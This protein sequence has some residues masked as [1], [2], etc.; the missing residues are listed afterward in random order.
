MLRHISRRR[1]RAGESAS[2][3][4]LAADLTAGHAAVPPLE[5]AGSFGL[6]FLGVALPLELLP[7]LLVQTASVATGLSMGFAEFAC[8][9]QARGGRRLACL[10]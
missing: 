2:H 8:C 4:Q 9:L 7:H 3:A 6:L 5:G 10:G 1:L